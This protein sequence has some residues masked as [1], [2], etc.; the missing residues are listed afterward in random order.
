MKKYFNELNTVFTIQLATIIFVIFDILPRETLL[1]SGGL[2]ALFA[3]R[4]S[5][6]ESVFMIARCIPLFTALPLTSG[7]DSFNVWRVIVLIIFIKWIWQYNVLAKTLN[8]LSDIFE[9]AKSNFRAAVA[10]AYKNWRVE[11]LCAVL[12][13]VSVLSLAKADDVLIGVKRIIYFINLGALFFIARSAANKNNINKIAFNALLSG[14]LI[15]FIGFV[16]LASAY[17]MSVDN[18]SDFWALKVE[19]TLYGTAWANI[20]I[21]ANTWFAYYNGTIHLRMFS[22][23]PDT[24][25]FPIYLLMVIGFAVILFF[26]SKEKIK[27]AA[28]FALMAFAMASLILTGTRGI[29]ASALFP[30]LLLGHLFFKKEISRR[31][32]VSAGLPLI[33]FLVFLPLS[34]LVFNSAQFAMTGGSAGDKVFSE[35]IK[36][37][38]DT[39]EVSNSGR[40]YIWKETLASIARN[41]ILG[42]GIGNFPTILKQN[43]T[44]IKAGASAHNL[45]LNFFAELGI[46]GF[47]AAILIIYEILKKSRQLFKNSEFAV[48]FF[49][50]NA[51]LYL[52]WILWYNMTDVAI[53]DER[54]FLLL[55]IFVGTI[56]ALERSDIHRGSTFAPDGNP[57]QGDEASDAEHRP[58]TTA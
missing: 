13:L 41:P 30:A 23:F 19:K 26:S 9:K 55:M 25:S 54:A 28:I 12:L 49:G 46:F 22:S 11:F 35:R 27:K 15:V 52:I 5:I 3:L 44:A 38:I 48:W 29:W 40:I 14:A 36:S 47:A 39:N 16:Q 24:H 17:Y 34:S 42:V 20:A 1:F 31:A 8:V 18:F 51:L 50:L 21:A 53:F 43:P 32:A 56:F 7:F 58:L 2:L 45:Y 37:I 10:F 4:G 57:R 33:L 6:E